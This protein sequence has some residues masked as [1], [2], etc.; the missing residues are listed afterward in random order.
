VSNKVAARGR[1]WALL[2]ATFFRGGGGEWVLE[3]ASFWPR[4]RRGGGERCGWLG[5]I[6][7]S[8]A[9]HHQ[10]FLLRG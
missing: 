9:H 4:A 2:V 7:A 1:G 5:I 10:P 8:V 6:G 3:A